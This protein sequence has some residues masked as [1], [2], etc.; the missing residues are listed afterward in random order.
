MAAPPLCLDRMESDPVSVVRQTLGVYATAPTAALSL[1]ARVSG[2][3]LPALR[4]ALWVDRA[5]VT[6][7]AMRG[8]IHLVAA[9]QAPLLH[10]ATAARPIR[11]IAG[12]VRGALGDEPY[13]PWAR[14][15]ED[16]LAAGPRSTAAIRAA[17]PDAPERV[18]KAL[19]YV[20]GQL[21]CEGRIVR[22][23]VD[24][25]W[26][27]NRW[28]FARW[29][30]WLPDVRL[31]REPAAA[32]A[33]LAARYAAAYGP[34]AESDF[35]WWAQLAARASRAAWAGVPPASPR[36]AVA[37]VRLLPVWD[38]LMLGA[39]DRNAFVDPDDGSRVY[40]ASGNPTSVVLLDGRVAGVWD[41][42]GST[43]RVAPLRTFD[44][45][46]WE[47]VAAEVERLSVLIDA[48][49][50]VRCCPAP[51]LASAPRNRFLAPLRGH[52]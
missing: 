13:E 29:S 18:R 42:D 2:F 37:G 30:D 31:D 52:R 25:G 4:R 6:M 10:A 9:D 44:S 47:A 32:R 15:V 12:I 40:D 36:P 26:R 3:S 8:S 49:T 34:V 20:V 27:S 24:G 23:G 1:L 48:P 41:L 43:V 46:T 51:D 33:E 38:V 5:L 21:A 22:C 16:L 7:P 45:P 35:R 19:R 39:R 17:F 11:S 14:R 50:L 28:V